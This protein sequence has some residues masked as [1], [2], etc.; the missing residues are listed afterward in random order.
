M[1][2]QRGNNSIGRITALQSQ[3]A[4]DS[5]LTANGT[6]GGGSF[7]FGCFMK[8]IYHAVFGGPVDSEDGNMYTSSN[9]IEIPGRGYPLAFTRTYNANAASIDGPLG[10][11]WVDNLGANLAMA[12]DP[13]TPGSRPRSPRRTAPR[14]CSP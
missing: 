13:S 7:C 6:R 9:D 8:S 10:F 5:F 12:G 1:V 3:N 11:G 14:R 2:H 4:L